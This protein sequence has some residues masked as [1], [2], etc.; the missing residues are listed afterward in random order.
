MEASALPRQRAAILPR[1]RRLLAAF[2]DEKLVDHI[3][4]GNAAAFEVAYDRHY[5]G[6]LSFCRHMLGSR[7]EA[8]DAVQ[9]TFAAAY[10]DLQSNDRPIRLKAWLYTIARNRCLSVLRARRE[11]AAELE[12]V[13]AL[14]G[15]SDEVQQRADLRELLQDLHEL[16]DEQ[17]E[18]LVLYEIGDMSQ[19]D[20][21]QV[22][23]VEPMKVKALVFQARSTLI[24]NRDAR[25]I[26]CG[27]IREQLATASGGALRRGPLRRHLKA[28]E[29]CR[30]YRDQVRTQR[31]ALALLLPVAPTLGLKD[32]VLASLGIGGGAGGAGAAAG[33]AAGG[34]ASGSGLLTSL[35]GAGAAK[36][37]V[38]V[39]VAAGVVAGGG[40]AVKRATHDDGGGASTAHASETQSTNASSTTTQSTGALGGGVTATP[41]G[42][43]GGRAGAAGDSE[44]KR[45][46]DRRRDDQRRS[47][48]DGEKSGDQSNGDNGSGSEGSRHHSGTGSN[49]GRRAHGRGKGRRGNSSANSNSHSNS[50]GRA[51]HPQHPSHSGSNNGGGNAK[52]PAVRQ[53]QPSSGSGSSDSTDS[54]GGKTGTRKTPAAPLPDAT[55]DQAGGG[56]KAVD[57]AKKQLVPD[58][59]AVPE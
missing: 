54:T 29:G 10:T 50:N 38:G 33:G 3:R 19:A 23:G 44:R 31:S 21:A 43:T 57:D 9:Q 12:D 22:I 36:L 27:E 30:E 55:G 41:I 39:A 49:N 53:P 17:R 8:E 40:M 20:V 42:T 13:P 37:A 48:D 59:P 45:A 56:K 46:R 1:S 14:G 35:G 6:I 32:S 51:N 47:G 2:P 52:Q 25:S 5:R 28:C 15:L 11:Q 26:P 34:A 4:R 58:A 18:A 7:E 24:E 16:P